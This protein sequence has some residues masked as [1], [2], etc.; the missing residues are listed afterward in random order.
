MESSPDQRLEATQGYYAMLRFNTDTADRAPRP[1][2]DPG[3]GDLGA[4]A[5]LF[6]DLEW[7]SLP[8]RK[9][10]L[11]ATDEIENTRTICAQ[12]AATGHAAGEGGGEDPHRALTRRSA[13]RGPAC[14]RSSPSA[15]EVDI[16]DAPE[17]VALDVCAIAPADRSRGPPGRE[18]GRHHCAQARSTDPRVPR[19]TR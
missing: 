14:S 10:E 15:I 11:L 4:T 17:P 3:A 5:L 1:A 16:P 2:E 7:A 9:A 19:P 8:T 13:A 12:N 6:F 18:R